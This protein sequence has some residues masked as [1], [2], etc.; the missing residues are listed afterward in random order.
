MNRF[1]TSV[2][3][4]DVPEEVAPDFTRRSPVAEPEFEVLF[5]DHHERGSFVEVALDDI[6]SSP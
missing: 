6:S 1:L 2:S 3:S 5:C 4:S